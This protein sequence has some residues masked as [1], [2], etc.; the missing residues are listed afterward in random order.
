MHLLLI[1]CTRDS[2]GCLAGR[3]AGFGCVV[4]K[5]HDL[6]RA[7]RDGRAIDTSVIVIDTGHRARLGAPYVRA[8]REAGLEQPIAVLSAQSDWRERVASL[9]AGADDYMVKP[10]R[11]EEMEA[12]LRAIIRRAAG[13]ARD[14]IAAGGIEIDLKSRSAT[15]AGREVA[16]TRNEFRLLR[17]FLL[18]PERSYSCE[19]IGRLLYTDR[20]ARS[21]NAVE[22]HI[23]R[24]RRKIGRER[25][26][27]V[28]GVGYRFADLVG[29]TDAESAG[30]GCEVETCGTPRPVEQPIA[31]QA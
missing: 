22:V 30:C 6:D 28:R 8:L 13:S 7:I 4:R 31:A 9:D 25:I 1:D 26:R 17:L 29:Q 15:L 3:L 21:G 20:R 5:E 2:P 16:L 23:A 12:R 27:T 10:M 19:E 11:A 14:R 18:D 24:L